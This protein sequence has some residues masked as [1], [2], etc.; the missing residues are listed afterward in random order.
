MPVT[1][2]LTHFPNG[3]AQF[4]FAAV[5]STAGTL[6][7]TG[8]KLATDRLLHARFDTLNASTGCITASADGTSETTITADDQITTTT[9]NTTGKNVLI[10]VARAMS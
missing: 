2:K 7:C 3:I 9:T 8:V 6:T 4:T 10:T 1:T 5:G